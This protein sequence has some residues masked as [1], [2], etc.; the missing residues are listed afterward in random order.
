VTGETKGDLRLLR[1]GL[2][3]TAVVTVAIVAFFASAY[4]YWSATRTT[5]EEIDGLINRN[6]APGATTDEVFDF[7]DRE[8]LPYSG[9]GRAGS[10][11]VLLEAG[12]TRDTQVISSIYRNSSRG[13]FNTIN[14]GDIDIYFI[15][16]G[17]GRYKEHYLKEL[18]T[19]L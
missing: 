13:L 17:N 15:L 5:T 14:K 10:Y 3:L 6:L 4:I 2:L 11:T 19:S 18:Y 16:D 12:Y 9:I 1:L 7:L 8:N